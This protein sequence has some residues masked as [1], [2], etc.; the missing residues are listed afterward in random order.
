MN[1][2]LKLIHD[3]SVQITLLCHRR[4]ELT[5]ELAQIQIKFRQS[6]ALMV[7]NKELAQKRYGKDDRST[8]P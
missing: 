5:E 7:G 8:K 3:A 2:L 6:L 1:E 4:P